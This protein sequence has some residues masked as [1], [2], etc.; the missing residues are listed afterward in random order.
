MELGTRLS[1]S[2]LPTMGSFCAQPKPKPKDMSSSDAKP[3][4]H[5]KAVS[6]RPSPQ[7]AS[8]R[9]E[10]DAKAANGKKGIGKLSE[11]VPRVP[12]V[13]RMEV[14]SPGALEFSFHPNEQ[15]LKLQRACSSPAPSPLPQLDLEQRRT[16]DEG[17]EREIREVGTRE[18]K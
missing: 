5:D 8:V 3:G 10:D 4:Q 18:R 1:T 14:E 9:Q 17:G 2:S 16:A 7:E 11:V 13:Q 12:A 6:D 15:G